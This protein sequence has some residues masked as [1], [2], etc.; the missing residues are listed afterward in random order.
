MFV[1]RQSFTSGEMSVAQIDR[2][3]TLTLGNTGS[4]ISLDLF[5][6][7]A[8]EKK[9]EFQSILFRLA[10]KCVVLEGEL[11]SAN[12]KIKTFETSKPASKGLE[13]LMDL[14]PKKS[15]AQNKTKQSKT[16]MSVVNPTSRKRKAAT[17]VIFGD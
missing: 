4:H 11:N 13:A 1:H 14:S 17:G 16:G 2:K 15:S 9:V 12:R 3:I 8:A 5:E 6:A 7:K 10:E